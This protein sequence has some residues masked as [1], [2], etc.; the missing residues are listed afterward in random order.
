MNTATQK[1]KQPKGLNLLL[2]TEG[3]ERFGY[4]TLQTI[5]VLYMTHSLGLDQDKA[6]L[7]FAACNAF[8]YLTPPLGGY[9]ADRYLGF[10]NTIIIGG[11]LLTL[12][13]A[14]CAIPHQE[15]FFW[16]L[17]VLICANGLFKPN[18]SSI[19]GELYEHN[20]PR[21]EGGFTLFYMG[22]NVGSLFPP[23]IA[24]MIMAH[25]P[26]EGF[27]YG[28]LLAVIGM[29]VGVTIFYFGRKQLQHRGTMPNTSPL[30][31]DALTKIKFAIVFVVGLVLAIGFARLIFLKPIW[32][33]SA[34]EII[35]VFII[36][37][38]LRVTL[39]QPTA[40][41][42]KM[43][44]SLVLIIISIGFWAIYNQ[45]F[46]SLMLFADSNMKQ[47][48]LGLPFNA[49]GSQFFNPFF[50][51]V[52]SPILSMLWIKLSNK[53]LNP[54]VPNKFTLAICFISLGFFVLAIGVRYFSNSQGMSASGW[55]MWSYFLQ[56]IGE[57]L[58][59]PIGLAMITT[60]TPKPFVGMM[61][62]VWFFSQAASFAVGGPLANISA[63][64]DGTN[65][66]LSQQIYAHGFFIY[67]AIA[68]GLCFISLC[69][70]PMLRK[71]LKDP[72]II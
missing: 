29:L 18:I 63:V 58:L 38:A 25:Y 41:R 12:A 64:P 4:Y 16:G 27:H 19:V 51:I 22:I 20:D 47:S 52:L 62:G 57:L 43:L 71:L 70:L 6:N 15:T 2:F 67:A 61:M 8:L 48:F 24:A 34:V 49:Y 42:N 26:K 72:V 9:I 50:I 59:S 23:I 17:A 65:T 46:T 69:C 68:L 3:W 53:N 44:V 66:I 39:K 37:S 30:K 55:L 36:G 32:S 54:S 28:F 10:Q 33:T 35:T 7:L 14:L 45:T 60:L 31:K 11:L 40:D 5:I 1:L 13:Y 56:T 21:R